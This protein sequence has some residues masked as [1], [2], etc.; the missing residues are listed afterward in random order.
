MVN[1][2]LLRAAVADEVERPPGAVRSCGHRGRLGVGARE[3]QRECVSVSD[4][5]PPGW[6]GA[7][8][9]GCCWYARPCPWE[10]FGARAPGLAGSGRAAAWGRGSGHASGPARPARGSWSSRCPAAVTVPVGGTGR[11]GNPPCG[12]R[13]GVLSLLS[14]SQEPCPCC[15]QLASLFEDENAIHNRCRDLEAMRGH[16]KM[17]TMTFTR[18]LFLHI[19]E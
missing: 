2:S 1:R 19:K 5:G 15:C 12:T 11:P 9:S 8:T 7:G 16:S 6:R 17:S 10:G 18:E 13:A 14:Q 4:A 3:G